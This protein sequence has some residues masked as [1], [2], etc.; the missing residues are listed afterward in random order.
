MQHSLTIHTT[1]LKGHI[2]ILVINLNKSILHNL[3]L[4]VIVESN[5]LVQVLSYIPV[6]CFS[7]FLTWYRTVI[8]SCETVYLQ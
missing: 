6:P 4:Q 8:T 1:L 5:Q 7:F 2:Q 3:H